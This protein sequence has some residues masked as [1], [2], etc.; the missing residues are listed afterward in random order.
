MVAPANRFTRRYRMLDWDHGRPARVDWISGACFVARRS[1]WDAVGGFDPSYFMYMEDVDL[2]W[3]M[4][5]AGWAVG[6][7]PGVEVRHVQGVSTNRHPYRMLAAHHLSMWRFA[8]RTTVGLKRA[9]LPLV[10]VGLGGRFVVTVL[11]H[12]LGHSGTPRMPVSGGPRGDRPL[13]PLP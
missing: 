5:R 2:C 6:Y 13:R 7:Q 12:R 8:L 4:G 10:G 11:G 1:A 9:A 3:R